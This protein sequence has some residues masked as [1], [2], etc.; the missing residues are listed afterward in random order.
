[1]N[2]NLVITL[3][4]AM[5]ATLASGCAEIGAPQRT[6][7]YEWRLVTGTD[8]L[9]FSWPRSSLPVK[10]WA[11]SVDNLDTD[12]DASIAAWNGVFLYGE[13]HAVRVADSSDADVILVE[14]PPPP[15]DD[16]LLSRMA[17]ERTAAECQAATLPHIDD[18]H[19]AHL[20]MHI[21]ITA[22][23]AVDLPA[24]RAC[25][26]LTVTHELGHTIGIFRHSPHP[27]DIMY[28][29]P[30]VTAPSERDRNTAEILYHT[31]ANVVPVRG[32]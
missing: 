3:G 28:A 14:G 18:L 32:P 1:M 7:V 20:P 25:F 12:A 30:T 9:N 6:D 4:M 10:I 22:R 17:L 11:E 8:T 31:P 24:T 21:Y 5:V 13:Y 26:A 27:E 15:G 19:Q 16:V 29:N 23:F 2:R